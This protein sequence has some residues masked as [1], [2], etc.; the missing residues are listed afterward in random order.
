MVRFRE[1]LER[2]RV[3][4][5]FS[6]G[7]IARHVS[8]SARG[9]RQTAGAA[10]RVSHRLRPIGSPA[11]HR[12]LYCSSSSRPSI[13]QTAGRVLLAKAERKFLFRLMFLFVIKLKALTP[14]A[15]QGER[16]ERERDAKIAFYAPESFSCV[17]LLG[18]YRAFGP[19][20]GA[21]WV[22]YGV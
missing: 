18:R 15:A 6:D 19:R 17:G 3:R 21:A 4:P 13:T 10:T 2:S 9:A 5:S 22:V 12:L 16:R 7:A 8:V 14:L 1:T 20:S 11:P